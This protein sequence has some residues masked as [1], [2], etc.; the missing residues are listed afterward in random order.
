MV[1]GSAKKMRQ[2]KDLEPR[3]DSLGSECALVCDTYTGPQKFA[4]NF[5]TA[6]GL[7][8]LLLARGRVDLKDRLR[9]GNPTRGD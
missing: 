4:L 9:R 7:Y 3:S 6:A 2:N 1:P 5:R 8:S